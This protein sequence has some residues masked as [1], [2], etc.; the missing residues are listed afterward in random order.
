MRGIR[1]GFR[2]GT[3]GAHEDGLKSFDGRGGVFLA[4]CPKMIKSRRGVL[5]LPGGDG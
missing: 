2:L 5:N 3:L 4:F 1:R